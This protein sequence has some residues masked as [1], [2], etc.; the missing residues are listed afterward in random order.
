MRHLRRW[1]LPVLTG[2]AVLAAVVL[3]RQIS[4][5]QDRRLLEAIHIESLSEEDLTARE[6]SL[7]E[8]LELLCRAVQYPDLQIFSTTQSLSASD[9]PEAERAAKAFFKSVEYLLDWG[10]LPG[11]IDPSTLE[12]QG[13]SRAVYVRSDGYQ[14]VSMLYLQGTSDQRDSFW[15]VIDEETGLPVWID[16][17]LRSATKDLPTSEEVGDRFL[18]GLK[19]EAQ[20]R[21]PT[22]WEIEGTEGLVYSAH[23]ESV[24]GRIGAQPIGFAEDL[25][26]GEDALSDA[27]SATIW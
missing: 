11:S 23:S 22:M 25:F 27:P 5:L 15:L 13:G 1:G 12:F 8:K 7:P 20:Q 4:A 10:V 16:C 2:L 14:S 9:A 17:T 21:S 26:G 18:K 6:I 3:P 19:L 24:Y